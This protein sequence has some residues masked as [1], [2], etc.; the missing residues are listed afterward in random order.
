HR[1][2]GA[3]RHRQREVDPGR[4]GGPV[5]ARR[6]RRLPVPG[7][8]GRRARPGG[9]GRLAGGGPARGGRARR[10]AAADDPG[11]A[12]TAPPAGGQAPGG[13]QAVALMAHGGTDTAA[14]DDFTADLDPVDMVTGPGNIY[15]TAAK[16]LC[17][18]TV[19]I[20]AEAGPTEVAILADDTAD[21]VHVAADM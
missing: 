19:G 10:A 8:D 11:P 5:R 14:V 9:R 17:R 12:R 18:A 2:R 16:R 21:P 6:Q 13:A 1:D 4:P 15:V 3:R 20:D 7:G